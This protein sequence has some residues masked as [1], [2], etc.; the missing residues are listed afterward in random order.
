MQ[1]V[2]PSSKY[3]K[4]FLEMVEEYQ[5]ETATNR[6][7]ISFLKTSD[8]KKH[9]Q[10]YVDQLLGESYGKHLPSGYVS[11]TTYWLI[12]G[13]ELI[14]RADIRHSL[15]EK[16]LQEG[17]HIG[18]DIRPSKRRKGYGRDILKLVLQKV[19]TLGLTKVLITCDETNSGSKKI[20][21]ANGGIFENSVVVSNRKPKKLRYWILL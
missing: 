5:R 4:S 1:L 8:L 3:K 12:D 14:G 16:L 21:E 2:I 20:I 15:T 17:G 19:K 9:F 18:Y 11:H 6:I 10:A 13:D 7:D